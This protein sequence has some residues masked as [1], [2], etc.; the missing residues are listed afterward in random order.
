[1]GNNA[2][3]APTA[4]AVT[5][6]QHERRLEACNRS[7]FYSV[8]GRFSGFARHAKSTSP[9][10]RYAFINTHMRGGIVVMQRNETREFRRR[11]PLSGLVRFPE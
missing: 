6:F 9:T 8:S 7:R 10:Q 4:A 3:A 11:A 2:A 1:M 5:V